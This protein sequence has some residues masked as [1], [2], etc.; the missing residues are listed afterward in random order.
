MVGDISI[1]VK[2]ES[3]APPTL[4]MGLVKNWHDLPEYWHG[5]REIRD[6]GG[7][8][9][10]IRFAFPATGKMSYIW[11]QE[12]M[13][14]T[15]N[16]HSGPFTGYKMLEFRQWNGGTLMVAKWEIKLSLR[17]LIMKG[18]IKRHFTEGTENALR[19]MALA[20]QKKMEN[21][22]PASP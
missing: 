13:K 3:D 5:I 7:G 6:V 2:Q 14:C 17:I 15:E 20:A 1:E 19:R 4:L 21:L 11:D 9:Y 8:M 16:Y 10:S 18:F 22:S 12:N